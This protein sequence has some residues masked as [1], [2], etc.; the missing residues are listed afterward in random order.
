[1]TPQLLDPTNYQIDFPGGPNQ[2][3]DTVSVTAQG[4]L[5]MFFFGSDD[6]ATAVRSL[7]DPTDAQNILGGLLNGFDLPVPFN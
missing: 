4:N 3:P 5:Q 2:T 1:M 7:I 6:N